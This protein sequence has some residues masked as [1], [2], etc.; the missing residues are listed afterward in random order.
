VGLDARTWTPPL[1]VGGST[2]TQ[3]DDVAV[4]NGS[5]PDPGAAGYR[6]TASA[7]GRGGSRHAGRRTVEPG[8]DGSE[9]PRRRAGPRTRTRARPDVV[10]SRVSALPGP[11]GSH[12]R[13]SVGRSKPSS[14]WRGVPRRPGRATPTGRSGRCSG[15]SRS[16]ATGSQLDRAARYRELLRHL[17]CADEIRAMLWADRQPRGSAVL[18]GGQRTFTNQD[19]AEHHD[20]RSLAGRSPRRIPVRVFGRTARPC[21]AHT[22]GVRT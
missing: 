13:A 15:R 1:A 4:R 8:A 5:A 19:A 9:P 16:D 11:A 18:Y 21:A 17:G 20:P 12:R 6:A 7:P 14:W 2:A 22:A 3:V 10:P